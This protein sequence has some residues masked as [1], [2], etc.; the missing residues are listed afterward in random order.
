MCRLLLL[1]GTDC[2]SRRSS[3][4]VD[5]GRSRPL[6]DPHIRKRLIEV[7]R[8]LHADGQPYRAFDVFNLGRYERQWWQKERLKGADEEHRRVVLEFFKAEILANPP[9][10]LLH[11]RKG[12]AFC[13]VD[14]ID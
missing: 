1:V 11:G 8:E 4:R 5:H 3:R 10:P 2:C 7:Q 9:S 13:H 14:G 12:A 6:R